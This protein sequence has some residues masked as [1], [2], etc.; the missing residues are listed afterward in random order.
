[1]KVGGSVFPMRGRKPSVLRQVMP[2]L[3]FWVD[4]VYLHV[5]TVNQ[6]PFGV[7]CAVLVALLQE[8]CGG[9][10][11]AAEEIYYRMLSGLEGFGY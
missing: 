9:F 11:K 8:I 10:G 4:N 5:D 3:Q 1:M 7:S 6:T 2:S